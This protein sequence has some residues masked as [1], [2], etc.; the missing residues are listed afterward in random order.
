VKFP[1]KVYAIRHNVTNRVYIGSSYHIDK[2]FYEHLSALRAHRHP[3]GD[4]QEDF[5]KYGGDFTLTVLDHI[6]SI[7][8]KD[9]EY[10]W[11]EKNQSY[12]RG[13]GYNY[14]DKKWCI[15][16][17][18]DDALFKKSE[19]NLT[20]NEEELI[21][22]IRDSKNPEAALVKAAAIITGFLCHTEVIFDAS[23]N[24]VTLHTM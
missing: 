23:P 2:R 20:R 21:S 9:K 24:R 14:K 11:M 5:D 22:L 15:A 4:M 10:E 6:S 16:E 7:A 19:E 13:V 12:I 1:R 8:E 17:K 18:E 3:V